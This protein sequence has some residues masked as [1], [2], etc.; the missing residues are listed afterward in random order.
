MSVFNKLGRIGRPRH[1]PHRDTMAYS[2]LQNVFSAWSGGRDRPIAKATPARLRNF[3]R[4]V[5]ARRAIKVIKDSIATKSF[6]IGTKEGVD[7]TPET[8][9]QIDLL[10]GCLSKPNRDDSWRSFVEQIVEDICV[11]GAGAFEHQQGGDTMRPLWMWPVDALSIQ[12][13]P[14]WDGDNAK[15][16][17][18][19]SLGYGNVGTLR[20]IPLRNDELVYVRSDPSTETPFGLGFVEVAFNTI[21]RLLSTA[22]YAG[23]VAGNATKENLLFFKGADTDELAT[24]RQYWIDEIEGQGKLPLFGGDDVKVLQLRGNKDENLFLKYQELLIRELGAAAGLSPQNFGVERDVNRDTAE[25]AEDRDYRQT[26]IPVA[27]LVT[28]HIN[29]E[30][31][32]EGMGFSQIEVRIAGLDREDE[33]D[34][35]RILDYR[36][37]SNSITVNE[38]RARYGEPPIEG[39]WGEMTRADVE[40][41]ISAARGAQQVDDPALQQ[42]QSLVDNPVPL[43]RARKKD[44]KK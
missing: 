6:E 23:N 36:W 14:S 12:I 27:T 42:M 24:I 33:L 34:T 43:R 28:S 11:C 35:A 3:S 26:I 4:N 31:I 7:S 10:A 8:D 29:R 19:Q 40:I 9:R 22:E 16:R 15:P 25:V 18:L 2:R 39:P 13:V 32:E 44:R 5:Y 30:V 41:A 1:E 21:N 17:Y 38:I 20:G 37:K